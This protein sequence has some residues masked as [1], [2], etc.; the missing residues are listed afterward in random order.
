MEIFDGINFA[1]YTK[2]P[3]IRN[4]AKGAFNGHD[5][6]LDPATIRFNGKVF[7]YYSGLGEGDDNIGL[8]VSKD[9]YAFKK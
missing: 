4:G 6:A 5:A 2:N 8:A 1:D 7:L 3:I 9:Y